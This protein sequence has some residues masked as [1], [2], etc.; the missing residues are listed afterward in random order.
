MMLFWHVTV[1]DGN[2]EVDHIFFPHDEKKERI[3]QYMLERVYGAKMYEF[4]KNVEDGSD[5]LVIHDKKDE[6]KAEIL[7]TNLTADVTIEMARMTLFLDLGYTPH[8]MNVKET[9]IAD[10]YHEIIDNTG[11][12]EAISG[13]VKVNFEY[14]GEG[15]SG[16]Y[17]KDDP[18]DM[19]LWRFYTQKREYVDDPDTGID[20]PD[21]NWVEVNE[22]SYCTQLS[23]STSK[24]VMEKLVKILAKR[25]E[26]AVIEDRVKREGE[27]CSWI[28]ETWIK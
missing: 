21:W 6:N 19:P 11:D 17:D 28:D 10:K 25:M 27:E 7:C 26:Q 16:E 2:T 8:K 12:Y 13:D 4:V 9:N 24:D 14:I 20:H 18:A 15:Y 5:V 22:G 23:L 3:I 1:W